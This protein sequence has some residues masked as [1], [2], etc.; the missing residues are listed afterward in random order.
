MSTTRP[1]DVAVFGASGY[2]GSQ[3]VRELLA[4]GV[5]V[6]CVGRDRA[7]LEAIVSRHGWHVRV[8]AAELDSRHRLESI[9][10]D[11][12]TVVN[13]AGSFVETCDPIARAAIAS[14]S[15]YVD[16]SGE[17]QSIR[18]VFDDLHRPAV[19]AGIAL[20][21]S[22]AFYATLADLLVSVM[23]DDLDHVDAIHI[24]YHITD[25][26][27]SGA[28][29]ANFLRGMGKPI[30]QFDHGLIEVPQPHYRTMDFGQ[31]L[32]KLPTFTYPAPEVL[33]IPR[34]V[35]VD[36]INTAVST[37]TFKTMI[38]DRL[39]P[40]MT[41]VIG[42]GLAGPAR[43]LVERV[44]STTTGS[45]RER[46]HADPTTFRIAVRLKADT[47]VRTAT[48]DS[49]GIFD[50]TSPI[51]A[52]IATLTLTNTFNESGALAPAEIVSNPRGLLNALADD[53]D[54]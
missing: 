42:R 15:H 14:G 12:I 31:P 11:V 4:E 19:A 13:A 40:A 44:L 18:S 35:N 16:I 27:P 7:K 43:P 37:S 49:R 52:T 45:S 36:R 29:Y 34:H 10:A 28:A 47:V 8:E 32:G 6:I 48:F 30:I 39:T 17:P 24:G 46:I 9:C 50:I 2:T 53:F 33:T 5:D 51:A 3:I 21:P 22:A 54:C 41:R 25:W 26:I 20:V 38:P 23:A 1:H